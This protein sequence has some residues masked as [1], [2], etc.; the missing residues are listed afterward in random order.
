MTN[1]VYTDECLIW[2]FTVYKSIYLGLQDWNDSNDS[3]SNI[4]CVFVTGPGSIFTIYER[5]LQFD[6]VFWLVSV[7]FDLE[8]GSALMYAC[9]WMK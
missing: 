3:N 7:Y 8:T 6:Y 4:V 9:G 2:L 1:S 5:S